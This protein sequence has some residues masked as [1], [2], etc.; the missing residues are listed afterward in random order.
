MRELTT[1]IDVFNCCK[2]RLRIIIIKLYNFST[3]YYPVV[4]LS[5]W[6]VAQSGIELPDAYALYG[7]ASQNPS[8]R[9]SGARIQMQSQSA[10]AHLSL[11]EYGRGSSH[12]RRCA[13]RERERERER[14]I[15]IES[16]L[17]FSLPLFRWHTTGWHASHSCFGWHSCACSVSI[18]FRY[19]HFAWVDGFCWTPS[20]CFGSVRFG[21]RVTSPSLLY[22]NKEAPNSLNWPI[23]HATQRARKCL[24]NNID[25]IT[26]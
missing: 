24:S 16:E 1:Q 19:E 23:S 4:L 14:P 2:F 18:P 13:E 22:Q 12:R 7:N 21:R 8:N 5:A 6:I 15:P 25:C 9:E 20:C 11:V 10:A 26:L 3:L 17:W